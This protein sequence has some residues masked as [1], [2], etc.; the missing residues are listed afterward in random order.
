MEPNEIHQTLHISGRGLQS[1]LSATHTRVDSLCGKPS[2]S[3]GR[4]EHGGIS[5]FGFSN[6]ALQP[7]PQRKPI[8]TDRFFRL[9]TRHPDATER[10]LYKDV[11]T[12]YR[13]DNKKWKPYKKY[14]HSIGRIVHVSPQDPDR[15]YLRL[16]LCHRRS[17]KSYEDLR[18]IGDIVYPTFRDA[19]FA[20]GYLEDDQEW[21]QCLTEAAA[22]RCLI[23]CASPL[24]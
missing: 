24:Q 9:C 13:W 2:N 19:A 10:L 23:N 6:L 22:E 1:N 4:Y 8:K 20:L 12:K 16:L 15:Y 14:V 18:G 21:S 5:R 3:F 7:H 17:P 11:P